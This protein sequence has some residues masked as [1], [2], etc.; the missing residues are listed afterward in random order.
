M[1]VISATTHIILFVVCVQDSQ[2][3]YN[4]KFIGQA[5]TSSISSGIFRKG[6]K[7]SLS[8]VTTPPPVKG[9]ASDNIIVA[10]TYCLYTVHDSY[11]ALRILVIRESQ[12]FATFG[13]V[14]LS[15]TTSL[16]ILLPCA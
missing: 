2:Q 5:S 13:L 3:S 1:Y 15:M 12:K 8:G 6:S 9:I 16:L 10:R 4:F 11:M 14:R 7:Q